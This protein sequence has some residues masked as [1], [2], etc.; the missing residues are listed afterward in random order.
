MPIWLRKFTFQ[1]LKDWYE[2]SNPNTKNEEAFLKDQ[3]IRNA[4]KQYQPPQP[5]YTTSKASKK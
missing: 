4:G 3:T 2:K 5:T 1:K